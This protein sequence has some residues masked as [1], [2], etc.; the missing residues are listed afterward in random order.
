M[1]LERID[2]SMLSEAKAALLHALIYAPIVFFLHLYPF[3]RKTVPPLTV[4]KSLL[5]GSVKGFWME[6][7]LLMHVR[8]LYFLK[9]LALIAIVSSRTSSITKTR[10][11]V[12]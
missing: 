9:S 4:Y 3:K 10:P 8:G 12:F 7:F 2:L 11:S 6:S 5:A 1:S